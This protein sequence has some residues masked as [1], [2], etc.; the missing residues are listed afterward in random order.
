MLTWVLGGAALGLGAYWKLA[1][2]EPAVTAI[3]FDEA[4]LDAGVEPWLAAQEARVPN[5]RPGAEKRVHWAGEAEARTDWALVYVHGFSAAPDEIRPVPD[6]VADRLGANLVFTRLKG[7]G[8][9]GPAMA[10]ATV[11]GWMEDMAEALAIGRRVGRR[12]LVMGTST[13]GTLITLALHEA[14]GRDVAGAVL[15]SPNFRVADPKSAL[16]TWPGARRWLPWLAGR[17]IG[18]EPRSE[19]HGRLWTTRYPSL[20]VLPMGAAVR[21]VHQRRHEDLSTPALF[22]FDPGDQVVDHRVTRKIAARWGG[23]ADVH[24]VTLGPEDDPSRHLIAGAVLSPQM[25]VPVA[26]RVLG[27][28][29]DGAQD[30]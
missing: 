5:L 28:I 1:P 15:I 22:V 26:E 27:W 3:S 2:R 23:T 8:R 14:M 29:L 12:V 10:E 9:D 7:H 21:A 24:E 13:G 6:I 11:E 25:S 4:Q 19:A 18:F 30:A 20:A 17:E 16:I